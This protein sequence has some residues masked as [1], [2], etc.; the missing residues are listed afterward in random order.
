MLFKDLGLSTELLRALEE[1]GYTQPTPVQAQAIPVAL[2]GRDILA[3]AQTGTG[4]TA[5]FSLPLLHKLSNAGTIKGFRPIRALILTPTRELATQVEQS[6]RD[7]GKY[8]RT[9]TTAL[10]GGVKAGPQINRLRRGVDIVVACPGRLLD[11]VDQRE[12]DLSQVEMLV[13]D[14]ADRMLDMGFMPSIRRI[15]KLLPEHRQTLFFSA[16][17]SDEIRKLA[18]GLLKSPVAIEIAQRNTTAERVNQRVHPVDKDRKRELLSELIGDGNW[19]QVLVF[20]RTKRGADRLSRQLV[21]DGLSATAIHGDKAQGARNKALADFKNG[22]ARVLVA[23][24]V[25]ARGLDIDQLPYVVNYDL[26]MVAEDYVHRIGRTGRAGNS[27]EAISLVSD[28]ESNLLHNIER[29]LK[30]EVKRDIVPGYEP[31]F[32]LQKTDLA[33]KAGGASPSAPAKRGRRSP[34]SNGSNV[35]AR[36]AKPRSARSFSDKPRS[37][38]SRSD[39]P[40]SAR[41]QGDRAKPAGAK[42]ARQSQRGNNAAN[43][44][45]G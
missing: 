28:D 4:K 6:I 14:E 26:P 7:Y 9:Y 38:R 39:Q 3:G 25:A 44:R 41:P 43:R 27:G 15:V 13:L 8:T 34:A 21:S 2:E 32:R 36:S 31:N 29:L 40:R 37:E 24:D 18:D 10:F 19:R 30:R 33:R 20:T 16:T 45:R 11:L 35:D 22:K 42:P 12:V 17:Y 1:Q 23:T 5:G